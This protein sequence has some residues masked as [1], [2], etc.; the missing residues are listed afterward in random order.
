MK[1]ETENTE[2]DNSHDRPAP[3]AAD[4]EEISQLRSENE[5]LKATLRLGEAHRQI[6]GELASAGA[7]SPELLFNSVKEDLQFDDGGELLNAAAIVHHL[8]TTFPEQFGRE[9]SVQSIDGGAGLQTG[10]MLTR[11]SLAHMTPAEIA[12]LDWSDVRRVLAS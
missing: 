12:A 1:P 7:R 2:H 4:H 9:R 3:T 6:T 5:Q 10:S 8:K 11:E